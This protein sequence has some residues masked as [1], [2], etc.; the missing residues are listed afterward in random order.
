MG[1]DNA[2]RLYLHFVDTVARGY[3]AHRVKDGVFQAIMEVALVNDGPVTLEL[4]ACASKNQENTASAE[5][6]DGIERKSGGS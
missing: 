1:G 4:Q 5:V 6:K 3:I 2:R